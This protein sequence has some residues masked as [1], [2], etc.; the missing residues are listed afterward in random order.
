[1]TVFFLMG[2]TASGKTDVAIKI[3]ERFPVRLISVDSGMV[4][5]GLNIGTAKPDSKLQEKAPH[6][7]I[8]IC[9]PAK[10][11][12]AA[13]FRKDAL[14]AIEKAFQENRVPL[15]VGGTMLYFHV[16]KY[17]LSPMPEADPHIRVEL[18]EKSKKIGWENM[19]RWLAFVDP[20]SAAFI[21]PNDPQRIQRALEVYLLT[22]KTRTELWQL[23]ANAF[24]YPIIPMVF[25]PKERSM[26]YQAI[27]QRFYQML[28]M[29]FLEEVE[30]LYQRKDLASNLPAIRLVGYRQA[31]D[32]LANKTSKVAMIESAIQATRQ[33]AKRQ[34][35][36]LKRWK[37]GE[38]FDS[39]AVDIADQV[40]KF[41][42][43]KK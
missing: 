40:F 39:Q 37:D 43:Q 23:A 38:I 10:P 24:P 15:L 33:L 34:I 18:L 5:R 16:L 22:G 4:Y 2:P 35:T 11:Y 6:D 17:G 26:L 21:H 14:N 7:L 32:F 20:S 1:M 29:G 3:A 19:H 9:D 31:W 42:K 30:T 8:D 13:R 41:L 27:T 25:L 12:S 28:E 36:W